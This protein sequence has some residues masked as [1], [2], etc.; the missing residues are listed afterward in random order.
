[1]R[2]QVVSRA[3]LEGFPGGK[4]SV[5]GSGGASGLACTDTRPRRGAAVQG[6]CSLS[7]SVAALRE[8]RTS[9]LFV[10]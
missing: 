5:W 3:Q 8:R 2:L 4:G 6:A 9:N 7:H 1:M 10:L